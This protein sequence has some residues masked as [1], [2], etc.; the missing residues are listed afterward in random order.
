VLALRD[1]TNFAGWETHA[2]ELGGSGDLSWTW[3]LHWITG[4][5]LVR[6]HQFCSSCQVIFMRSDP[7]LVGSDSKGNW[8][9]NC[10]L[11][12]QIGSQPA[13]RFVIFY[14][15]CARLMKSDWSRWHSKGHPQLTVFTTIVALPK[16]SGR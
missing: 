9:V 3:A 11:C 2:S 16:P 6:V 7:W 14:Q 13:V 10:P 8:S 1:S 4:D 12:R 15:W 5:W